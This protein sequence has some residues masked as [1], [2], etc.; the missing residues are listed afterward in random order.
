VKGI[1][2]DG[3]NNVWVTSPHALAEFNSSGTP[4]SG[5]GYTSDI[6]TPTGAI[7]VDG[8]GGVLANEGVWVANGGNGYLDKFSDTGSLLADSGN[9]LSNAAGSGAIDASG[10][11]WSPYTDG[12]LYF[13]SNAAWNAA[14][15]FQPTSISNPTQISID[16][17]NHIWIVSDGGV[18]GHASV[19]N[20]TELSNTG[21]TISPSATGYK[22]AT[23]NQPR[24]GGI[25]ASG[26]LWVVNGNN[27]SSV[28]EF[29]GIAAPT[30]MP[31]AAAAKNNAIGTRP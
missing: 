19:P 28:T 5:S 3:S 7:A 23:L 30:Y 8:G 29:V 14:D 16:G 26:N 20:I 13:G 11:F 6:N 24:G 15:N 22:S 25:D 18:Q 31:L 21:S 10:Q 12:V 4:I 2:I 17:A 27:G 1:A 9:V